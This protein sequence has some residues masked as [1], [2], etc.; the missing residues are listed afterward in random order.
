MLAGLAYL[1]FSFLGSIRYN[2]LWV[3]GL[4][5]YSLLLIEKLGGFLKEN[6]YGFFYLDDLSVTMLFLTVMV[7]LITGV[8]TISKFTSFLIKGWLLISIVF[9]FSRMYL[10]SFYIFFELRIIPILFLILIL[11]VQPERLNAGVYMVVYT[12]VGSIP[13]LLSLLVLILKGSECMGLVGYNKLSLT[14]ILKELDVLD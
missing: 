6:F 9:C 11:G 1:I 2:Y 7:C 8:Y 13:L 14:L 5:V 12:I 3:S 10:I 4:I